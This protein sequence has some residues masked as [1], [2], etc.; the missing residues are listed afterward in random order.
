MKT[1]PALD[2]EWASPEVGEKLNNPGLGQLVSCSIPAPGLKLDTFL[3]QAEGKS[4][5]FWQRGGQ[6]E[7]YAG[8][9]TAVQLIAWGENR[10]QEIEQKARQLFEQAQIVGEHSAPILPR[11]FGG[12]SFRDDF[13]ADNTWAA[14][15]PAHFVLPHYQF[16]QTGDSSWLTINALIPEVE[17]LD[18]IGLELHEA[19][20]AR[21]QYLIG[22]ERESNLVEKA[23]EFEVRYPMPFEIWEELVNNATQTMVASE[24][25]KVVL[26]RVCEI[27]AKNRIDICQALSF[28]NATY[29]EC[30][31]FLFEPRPYHAFYG[32]TPEILIRLEGKDFTTMALAGSMP[33]GKT[34][35]EDQANAGELFSSRKE[36]HEHQLVTQAI[37]RRLEPITSHLNI[38]DAPDVYRLSY[39]QHL[40]T[41][42]TGTLNK[43]SGILPLVQLL[44]PTPA[45]GGSP[46][47][48]AMD[49]IRENEPVPR[50]WYAA[51]VGWIDSQGDGEFIVAIRSAVAQERRVWCYAGAGIVL[52]S[53]PDREWHETDLKFQPMLR[54]LNVYR[55]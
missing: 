14:F 35:D 20:V 38:P 5:F 30:T 15:H 7:L 48:L 17:N 18:E 8:F 12:F 26:A 47:D 9:G 42:I 46:R 2:K 6:D 22:N 34:A 23:S 51:P 25:N 3:K 40:M 37:R 50:G 53:Q 11:L 16:V 29:Q 32:A 44:H 52:D 19:L 10:F 13:T 27:K 1:N 31:R 45:M 36:R 49:F 4:R 21:Y 33:R 28:L 54:A 24:L 43:Q 55:I 39:I 41:P